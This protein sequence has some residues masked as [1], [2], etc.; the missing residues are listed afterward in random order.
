MGV[1]TSTAFGANLSASVAIAVIA[2]VLGR[3]VLFYL[4]SI[5]LVASSFYLMSL[6][7]DQLSK[8]V[9]RSVQPA[10]QDAVWADWAQ[11]AEMFAIRV[12]VLYTFGSLAYKL[13]LAARPVPHEKMVA[14]PKKDDYTKARNTLALSNSAIRRRAMTYPTPFPNGWYKVADS[15]D[16]EVGDV[17]EV[18]LCGKVLC[19]FRGEVRC[20]VLEL[21]LVCQLAHLWPGWSSCCPRCILPAHGC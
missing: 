7:H 13:W 3:G 16:L 20:A 11:S 9:E 1:D 4:R 12:A 10:S 2:L 14:N 8:T 18:E 15:Q 21:L 17:K 6:T 19:V 5:A